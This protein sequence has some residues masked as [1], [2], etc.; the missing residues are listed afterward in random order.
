V[1]TLK[2]SLRLKPV[3]DVLAE[4][5]NSGAKPNANE[6][7]TEALRRVPMT[8]H[9][10]ELLSGGVPR[11]FKS[12]ATATARLVKAGWMTKARNGWG[13]TAEGLRASRG[14]SDA[15]ALADALE[16]GTPIPD[17]PRAAA[18]AAPS[19]TEP[20]QAE[21]PTETP[22]QVPAA[23]AEPATAGD[24]TDAGGAAGT[25]G[26]GIP[27]GQPS[28]VAVVGDFNTLMGANA[29]W[30]PTAEQTQMQYDAEEGV[31]KLHTE[32]P[33]GTYAFKFA[34]DRSWQENYGIFGMPDGANHE[35]HHG[36]GTVVFT[37]DH[38]THDLVAR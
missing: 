12:L 37:Y 7:I 27:E 29:D 10:Q 4:A 13:I 32:L 21:V 26:G 30:D 31:W 8:D 33:A 18:A 14:F 34:L 2:T 36:G 20:A 3:L 6:V 24:A 11:G 5:E 22:A 28:A 9:E 38:G 35:L 23:E 19:A 15:E 25:Q 1:A 16:N 17:V